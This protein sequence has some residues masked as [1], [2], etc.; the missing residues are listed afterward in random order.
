MIAFGRGEKEKIKPA[1]KIQGLTIDETGVLRWYTVA[2]DD[3]EKGHSCHD[4]DSLYVRTTRLPSG[5]C[6]HSDGT[7]LATSASSS[8]CLTKKRVWLRPKQTSRNP[9]PFGIRKRRSIGLL[10]FVP[11]AV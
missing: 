7:L 2:I 11:K 10:L 4:N 8:R 3:E 1:F 9:I 6:N 5:E